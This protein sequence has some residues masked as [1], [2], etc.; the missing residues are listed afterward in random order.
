SSPSSIAPFYHFDEQ[1]V[2][3]EV[4]QELGLYLKR[5]HLAGHNIP[6][7]FL[8]HLSEAQDTALSRL[9]RPR[10]NGVSPFRRDGLGHRVAHVATRSEPHVVLRS[11]LAPGESSRAAA[12]EPRLLG[13]EVD[14]FV[15]MHYFAAGENA[16]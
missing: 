4:F 14:E 13:G 1:R 3:V 16:A 2:A 12:G 6:Q 5:H 8:V 10:V 15:E 9:P 7:P 11:P